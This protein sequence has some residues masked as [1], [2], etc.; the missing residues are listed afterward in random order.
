[1]S[2][3]YG[4]QYGG[5]PSPYG[6]QQSFQDQQQLLPEGH[7][8]PPAGAP[9]LETGK[10]KKRAYA[11]D[12]FSVGTAG[13]TS[14]GGQGP[15]PSQYGAPVQ[16]AGAPAYGSYGAQA[17]PDVQDV[18]Y[19]HPQQVGIGASGGAAGVPAAGGYGYP[20]YG[21][22]G[23]NA[24]MPGAGGVDAV[25]AGVANM[26]ITGA[27]QPPA[28]HQPPHQQVPAHQGQ[29]PRT[30]PLNQLYPT[31]LMSQPFNVSELDLPPP[32]IMLPPNS[33]V[34]P[35]PDA[36]CPSK[37][38]RSTIN[39]VPTNH[40]LLKKSKLPFALIIQ[41]Y[42]S[43]HDL[44]DDVPVVQ[45]QVIS[46]CRR[47]RSY[48]N[49]FVTFVDHGHRWRCNM[50]NLTNDV[51]Q[52]FDWDAA[53]QKSVDRW[54]RHELNHAVVE[55]VAPQ[56]YMVRPPQPLVYLF[57]FDVSYAAV[58]TGLLATSAR[59]ILDS[60]NRIP[61]ADGRTRLGFI[62]VDSSL[63][64]FAIPRDSKPAAKEEGE[65]DDGANGDDE[66]NNGAGETSMLVVSDLDEPFMPV[67]QE[68]LVP[69]TS[70]RQSIELFLTKLPGM[71][72]NNQNNGS[73]M[74]SALRAGHKLISPLGGKMV[75]LSSSLPNMGTG[76]LEMREDKKVLGTSKEG[77]LLQTANS[78]YKS[79]A[80][81]CSKNQVSVDMFLFS[82]QYQ[83]VASLSN[84]PRYTGGQTW[85]YPG[86]NAGRPE[87]AI[88]FA[89][90]FSDYLS[91]E[92][93]LEAV[94]RV[95]ATT[96]LRMS[97]FY[98]NFFNRSSDL[99]AFPAFPRD[100]CYVVEVA[101]DETLQK[102][103]VCL[104]TAVLHTTCNG[105]R[106]IRVLTLALPTTLSLAD[107]YGS[108]DQ[109]AVTAYFSHK[110]VERALDGGLDA[111][112]D[113]LQNKL[114]ELLQ[115]FRKE[116]AGG[117]MGGGLQFPANLR[118]LPAL[119]LGLIKN[120]G[121]RK[122]A[123][124]PSDL[125]SA[126]LCQLSTLPVPLL[127][128]FIY[129]RLYSLHDMPDNAGVPDP[130]T[131][132]IVLPPPLNLSSERFVPYGLYL[133]DDG[134]TQFLWV[135]RDTVPQLLVDVFGVT[136]R[137]QLHVGK[138]S[139]PELDNDF[140]ERVRAVVQKSRDLKSRGVGS[141][142]VPHLYVVREDGEPS[143]KLWAQ[144]LLVEDRADHSMSFQQWMGN[145]REKVSN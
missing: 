107:V 64:Y 98:G 60:L 111:A 13:N 116:L 104:Q 1:M 133:I 2:A 105:E 78:F 61:N 34:T 30:G 82:S 81:E 85:F 65:E 36:N 119:F 50:C 5:Q 108:A 12:A 32:P 135:G 114:T 129:P 26:G 88:K 59:T 143:L 51:P 89:T 66:E 24:G 117:S 118:G 100:Q 97:S 41:P 73:S 45:D 19:G 33:S 44:D 55:F 35:S 70:S 58:S 93:G 17:T 10:K 86:W 128:Q 43:L 71:F 69:L 137:T 40:S 72:A 141:I 22:S 132:Q 52:A 130:E 16:P 57:L 145:L 67:P 92:I 80:V 94:L 122:S 11:A 29:P 106:R 25:T 8:P 76:K 87:D 112:R 131:S 144:T 42:A 84:L 62:A 77:A 7:A 113:S 134:Q 14:A 121:L 46:R 101:I 39:A 91:S 90:E 83:D 3:P 126:A 6:D 23:A 99:C 139:L 4:Q 18:Q 49:P 75:V 47:C 31:D 125:R 95:R 56:E 9:I 27:G 136:D 127:L 96:G 140:N 37:Y 53:S 48:I 63:H 120:V 138:T 68:L 124:I 115:T 38:V 21:Y 110:A 28:P 142:T 20:D 15:P 103:V 123:Q 74:G 79:F 102:N 109:A 54:Q